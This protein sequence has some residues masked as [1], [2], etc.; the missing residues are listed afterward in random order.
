MTESQRNFL[1]I[2]AIAVV[3]ALFFSG[4]LGAGTAI[5]GT[6][7]NIAFTAVMVALIVVLYQRHSG[8]IA[9][10]PSTPRLV[11]QVAT[12]A[13][14]VLLLGG[15]LAYFLPELE[16][17]RAPMVFWPALMLTGFAIWWSWQQRTSRW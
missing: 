14:I 6:L 4:P 7:L 5:A 2:I 13:L 12:V 8:T 10:M 1:I 11:L 9:T 3:G 15:L 17:L 16:V